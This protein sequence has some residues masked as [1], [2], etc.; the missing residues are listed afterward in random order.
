MLSYDKVQDTMIYNMMP[1]SNGNIFRVTGPLWGESTG[2]QWIPLTKASDM[3]LWCFLWSDLWQTLNLEKMPIA[4]PH[5]SYAM[6]IVS[7][8]EK[9]D[10]RQVSNT[11][12]TLVG[13]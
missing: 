11:R 10:Y 13:S 1:S 8:L 5:A 4:H 6:S 3:E 2:H 12:R 7:I 9:T